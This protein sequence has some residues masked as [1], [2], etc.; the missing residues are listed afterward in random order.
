MIF[1]NVSIRLV[2]S[3]S[4]I[5]KTLNVLVSTQFNEPIS[6][7]G[8]SSLGGK[9]NLTLAGTTPQLLRKMVAV[10]I[11]RLIFILDSIN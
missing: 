11:N 10:N 5:T 6:T 2:F 9:G 3:S 8:Y 7:F 1:L 4:L